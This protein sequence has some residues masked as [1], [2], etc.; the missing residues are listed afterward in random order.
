MLGFGNRPMR[1][2][3]GGALSVHMGTGSS[4]CCMPSTQLL[5]L[6]AHARKGIA[7][8]VRTAGSQKREYTCKAHIGSC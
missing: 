6:S 3:S 5:A 1:P 2:C 4:M 8:G 7:A